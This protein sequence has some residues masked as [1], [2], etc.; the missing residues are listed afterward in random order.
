MVA[1]TKSLDLNTV[2]VVEFGEM[3]SDTKNP[4]P[5]REIANLVDLANRQRYDPS[6]AI[7]EGIVIKSNHYGSSF[8]GK[9]ISPEYE[10]AHKL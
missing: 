6:G 2:P 4:H 1:I 10:V 5:Y 7:C 8:H 3:T 9:I